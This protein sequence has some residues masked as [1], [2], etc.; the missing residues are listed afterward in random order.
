MKWIFWEGVPSLAVPSVGTREGVPSL[1][2][3][4]VGTRE[5]VPSLAVPLVG[6]R[7]GVPSL[8]KRKAGRLY[9]ARP[10]YRPL[11]LVRQ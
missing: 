10:K 7:E 1:A 2:V 4:S 8:G 6:T 3:P 11:Y 5:G 9:D